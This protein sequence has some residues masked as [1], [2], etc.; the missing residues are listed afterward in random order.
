MA[1]PTVTAV[2]PNT[3][4]SRGGALVTITGTDFD[5]SSTPQTGPATVTVDFG[6]RLA[7]D[8]RVTSSTSLTCLF[9]RGDLPELANLLTVDVTVTNADQAVPNSGTLAAAFT[10]RRPDLTAETHLLAIVRAL[11]QRMKQQIIANVSIST[12]SDW[13]L[14]TSDLLNRVEPAAL[15]AVVLL[16]PALLLEGVVNYNDPVLEFQGAPTPTSF[17]RHDRVRSLDLDF[18]VRLMSA[19]KFELLNLIQHAVNFVWRTGVLD[20]VP[21]DPLLP[22]AGSVDYPLRIVEEFSAVDRPSRANVREAVGRWRIEGA[23]LG[24]NDLIESAPVIDVTDLL[25]GRAEAIP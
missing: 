16:G 14:R 24:T 10:Y 23:L 18:E 3:G 7:T 17:T 21:K 12:H 9:P 25:G 5:A 11:L 2:T 1:A 8:V 20:S 4:L 13:D 15:P 22:G 6:G 19:S